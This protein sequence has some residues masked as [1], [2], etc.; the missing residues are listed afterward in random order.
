[1]NYHDHASGSN[2]SFSWWR[3]CLDYRFWYIA[4]K[5]EFCQDGNAVVDDFGNLVRVS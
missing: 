4:G 5:G 3:S 1:M 2:R